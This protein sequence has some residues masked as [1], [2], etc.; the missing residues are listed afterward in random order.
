MFTLFC[1]TK[2]ITDDDQRMIT[3]TVGIPSNS[4]SPIGYRMYKYTLS[5]EACQNICPELLSLNHLDIIDEGVK[6]NIISLGKQIIEM[7]IQ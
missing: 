6:L 1:L 7:S 5:A 4:S 2:W 3:I